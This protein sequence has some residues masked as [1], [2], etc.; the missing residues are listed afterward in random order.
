MFETN[1]TN[2]Y[3]AKVIILIVNAVSVFMYSFKLLAF[4]LQLK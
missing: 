3:G 2:D 4:N 1:G